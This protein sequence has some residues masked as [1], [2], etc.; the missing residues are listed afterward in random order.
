MASMAEKL[1]DT[2]LGFKG[3]SATYCVIITHIACPACLLEFPSCYLGYPILEAGRY[4]RI[5]NSSWYGNEEKKKA[6]VH[7]DIQKVLGMVY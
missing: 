3:K 2:A 4:E 6:G 5:Q 1:K 7:Q